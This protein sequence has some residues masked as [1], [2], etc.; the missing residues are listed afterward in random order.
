MAHIS[1]NCTKKAPGGKDE[2]TKDDIMGATLGAAN[3]F[4]EVGT[5][6]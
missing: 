4:D 2:A 1:A 3:S 5:F 6:M